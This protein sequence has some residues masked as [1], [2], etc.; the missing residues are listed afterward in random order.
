MDWPAIV[1]ELRPL[2]AAIR[3]AVVAACE[4]QDETALSGI[5]EDG[6]GDT[7]YAI[8]R[9]SEETL[10]A[11]LEAG[12]ARRHPLLLVAEGIAGGQVLL[13]RGTT[14]A[15]ELRVLVDPIDGT[16]GLMYQK[17]PAWIL[18]GVA[19]ERGA[20]TRLSDIE[21][22][23]MTEIPLVRQHQSDQ[24]WAVRGGGAEGV[25]HDRL[26]GTQ[27]PLHPRPSRACDLAH[28]F[29]QIARF[30]PGARDHLAAID[31][32]IIRAVLGP[33][34][35]GKAACFEDQYISSGGQLA[36]LIRGADRFS[37]DLR[38][39][40][41]PLVRARG[42]LLGICCHPYDLAAALIASE[43]GVILTDPSG[44]PLDAPMDIHADVDW[45]GYANATIR[46]RVEP[47]LHAAL[48]RRGLAHTNAP[49]P[50]VATSAADHARSV[51]DFA[52]VL[53]ERGSFTAAP[54]WIARAPGRLDVM[55]G[56]ADYAGSLV[57]ELPLAAACL[58]AWQPADD[59]RF[60]CES[61]DES[62]RLRRVS[63]P[64]AAL[65]SVEALRAA[66]TGDATW[67]RYALGAFLVLPK[68]LP[69]GGRLA[70]HSTVPEARGVSS[71]AAVEVAALTAIAAGLGVTLTGV[72]LATLAQRVEHRVV[73]AP[74]GIMDQMTSA[75]GETDRLL[76][77]R[78]QPAVVE[79]HVALPPGVAA[80]GLDSGI[81]HAVGGSDYGSVRT[82]CFMGWRII[83]DQA[84]LAVTPTAPGRVRITDTRWGGFLANVTPAELTAFTLPEQLVGA[85]FLARYDGTPDDATTVDPARA[86]AVRA[87][88]AHPV[89]EHH[90][91][92]V[93]AALLGQGDQAGLRLAGE[94]MDQSH[95]S[96]SAC[97]L[98]SDGTDLLVRLVAEARQAGA[99]LYGAKITGGGS[100]GTVA[101]LGQ[102]AAEPVIHAIAADYARRTGRGGAVI[103]GS[104]PGAVASGA[105]RV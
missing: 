18:T 83:A 95:A 61:P 73:G 102:R 15:P 94:L 12:L 25:R 32:E 9:V 77:L 41:E 62:G 90:R 71:S 20:A 30:F 19:K 23:V 3:D 57:L 56:I 43:A 29:C 84:G 99:P 88:T 55:G 16:R 96:Y 85:D 105:T 66:T 68:T 63:V 82:A 13:P 80:W 14:A 78:C 42:E 101:V 100:G 79:G 34:R 48:A 10:I 54:L 92:Q 1:A 36:E 35:P 67:A 7:I 98:G 65:G 50:V 37:A 58:A 28:G 81:R 64:R 72:E 24:W 26:R 31:D 39:S 38:R 87:C 8:D 21:A 53:R 59:G 76:R 60:G 104:G 86:Y 49:A 6:E 22:A 93:F 70:L 40:I 75:L 4:R 47:A 11:A 45:V 97:G 5:A 44:A 51:A 91:V 74:C 69:P 2:H 33:V 103:A 27:A 89:H 52:H 17:R 46:A